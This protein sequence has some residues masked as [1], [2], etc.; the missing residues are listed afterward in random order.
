MWLGGEGSGS[1]DDGLGGRLGNVGEV[2]EEPCSGTVSEEFHHTAG[3]DL[4]EQRAERTFITRSGG[5]ETAA[6]TPLRGESTLPHR[7]ASNNTK[8]G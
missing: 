2:L 8:V 6:G 5:S 4:D 7:A 1:F 3:L